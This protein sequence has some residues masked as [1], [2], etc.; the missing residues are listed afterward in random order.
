M[1]ERWYAFVLDRWEALRESYWFVPALMAVVSGG[2]AIG[3]V[4]LEDTL[5]PRWSESVPWLTGATPAGAR[6]VLTTIAGSMITVTGV[7]FSITVVALTLA[8]SQFGPRLLRTFF[9]D[10]ASQIALGTFLSTFCYSLLVLREAEQPA[11]VPHLATTGAVLL[12]VIS[13]FVLIYFIHNAASSIQAASVI[14]AVADEVRRQI[15]LLYPEMIGRERQNPPDD[16]LAELIERIEEEGR[17]VTADHEGYVRVLDEAAIFEPAQAHGLV[18]LIA[19]RPGDFVTEGTPL[20]RVHPPSDAD[21]EIDSA[22]RAAFLLGNHR[23]PVQ[24]VRFLIDQLSEMAVRALSPG[25]SD[26]KTAVE[27]LHRLGGIVAQLMDREMPS[28]L[29]FDDDGDL[30][31]IA[32]PTRFEVLL[33]SCFDGIRRYGADDPLVIVTLLDAIA[34]GARVGG[35]SARLQMLDEHARETYEAFARSPGSESK[36]D[37]AIVDSAYES[38]SMQIRDALATRANASR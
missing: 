17:L 34:A 7:V 30:R 23:T 29:R 13:L 37:R 9:R 31:V 19:A 15:P 3:L 1:L 27:C 11:D 10:R 26:P 4:A 28:A 21:P 25:V 5:D 8:S 12:A 35:D 32:E 6:A 20:A 38:V 24:D 22:L 14:A 16:D 36:R 18:V 33:A 2:L